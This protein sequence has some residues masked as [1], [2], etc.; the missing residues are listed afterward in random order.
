MKE[1]KK[2]SIIVMKE[3]KFSEVPFYNLYI[4][5]AA[6]GQSALYDN[7]HLRYFQQS[8]KLAAF[9]LILCHT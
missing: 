7:L 3:S 8:Q 2:E 6:L 9:A 5:K 4:F 1:S